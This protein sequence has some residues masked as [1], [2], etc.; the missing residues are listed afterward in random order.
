M[1]ESQGRWPCTATGA[2]HV[3]SSHLSLRQ[4][5]WGG[6]HTRTRARRWEARAVPHLG[7]HEGEFR[8]R[9]DRRGR[10]GEGRAVRDGRRDSGGKATETLRVSDGRAT[11]P[12]CCCELFRQPASRQ[13]VG[14]TRLQA[15]GL[16]PRRAG[17]L[18]QGASR[19]SPRVPGPFRPPGAPRWPSRGIPRGQDVQRAVK[20]GT[21]DR[22]RWQLQQRRRWGEWK[23]SPGRRYSRSYV[24]RLAPPSGP[25]HGRSG[26]FVGLRG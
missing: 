14:G 22:S 12:P 23:T 4:P 8:S 11:L 18:A 21:G 20:L 19:S 15:K 17:P 1:S 5:P 2:L 16:T 6:V 25:R 9:W 10:A 13:L 24:S 3:A 7:V 26:S